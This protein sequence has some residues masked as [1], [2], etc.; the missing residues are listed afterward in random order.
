MTEE[1]KEAEAPAQGVVSKEETEIASLKEQ[2][3][4]MKEMNEAISAQLTHANSEIA[5]RDIELAKYKKDAEQRAKDEAWRKQAE[6][7]PEANRTEEMRRLYETDKDAFLDRVVS[8]VT[9]TKSMVP[10]KAEGSVISVTTSTEEK[11]NP[12]KLSTVGY[13]LI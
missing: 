8:I 9:S 12:D 1:M 5:S 10:Q 11:K 13:Y 7:L 6:R 2:I 3:A 4:K